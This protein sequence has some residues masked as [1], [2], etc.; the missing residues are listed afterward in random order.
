[1]VP[2]GRVY[3]SSVSVCAV[4]KTVQKSDK[5]RHP[6]RLLSY[7]CQAVPDPSDPRLGSTAPRVRSGIERAP[8]LRVEAPVAYRT[9]HDERWSRG[10]TVDIS[11]SGV[12]F[13]PSQPIAPES[14]DLLLV[15]FLSQS[16]IEIEG[17]PLPLPDMYCGG[18]VARVAETPRGERALAM[19]I[20]F[21]WAEKPPGQPPWGSVPID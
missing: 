13:V 16:R 14:G 8:R 2:T 4:P 18:R 17:T 15:I 3:S 20:E 19:Q 12:L 6:A 1:M 11:R 7:I 5:G 10:A 21:E 9:I